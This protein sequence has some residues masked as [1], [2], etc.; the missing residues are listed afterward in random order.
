MGFS[1]FFSS[2][3]SNQPKPLKIIFCV[4]LFINHIQNRGNINYDFNV[5]VN[6]NIMHNCFWKNI[7]GSISNI[8][9]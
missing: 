7:Y 1:I 6:L 4:L 5:L 9:I 2:K 8:A 3:A